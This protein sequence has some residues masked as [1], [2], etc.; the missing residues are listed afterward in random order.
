MNQYRLRSVILKLDARL[1]DADRQRFHFFMGNNVPRRIRDD[2][3]LNGTLT[4]MESLFDQDKINE[5]DF[6]FLIEAFEE[7]E[8][9]DAAQLLREY[10]EQLESNGLH[11][12]IQSLVSI[13]PLIQGR[14]LPDIP[15]DSEEEEHD[16]TII[17]NNIYNA[18]IAS[19]ENS[20]RSNNA[21][22]INDE[23]NIS[24]LN[25]TISDHDKSS[26]NRSKLNKSSL[27]T[28]RLI[29]NKFGGSGGGSF[30][31]STSNNFTCSS[32]LRGI[33]GEI[34]GDDILTSIQFIYSYSN[35]NKNITYGPIRG[36]EIRS[37]EKSKRFILDEWERFVKVEGYLAHQMV[38]MSDETE[39]NIV[40]VT[41]LQFTTATGRQSPL[42]GEPS[43]EKFSEEFDGFT[44]GYVKGKCGILI[45]QLQFIWYR[46]R[47]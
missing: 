32:Y 25:N 16:V 2:K 33:Y 22:N 34:D 26:L 12:S 1:S 17:N 20:S 21:R 41:G 31:D 6:T 38:Q 13:M 47:T 15:R 44:I 37:F 29:G 24:L 43:D 4:L 19:Q 7:I 14:F 42:F 30:D 27:R 23:T 40:V 36:D 46:R 11:Q 35:D 8:C 28:I 5:K 39:H 3:S 18:P 10:R 45:D 9:I